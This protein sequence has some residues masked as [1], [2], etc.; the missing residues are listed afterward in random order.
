[1]A[2]APLL[3]HTI[4]ADD[5]VPSRSVPSGN[6]GSNSNG[7]NTQPVQLVPSTQA[8]GSSAEEGGIVS[9]MTSRVGH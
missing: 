3:S 4:E 6:I 5:D 8:S 1:M 2:S 9:L 7:T